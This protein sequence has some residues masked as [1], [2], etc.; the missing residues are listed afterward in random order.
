MQ[1]IK[2]DFLI[3]GSGVIGLALARAILDRFPGRSVTIIEKELDV[4]FHG[5]GRNSG[6]L[7]AGFYYT[8]DSLKAKFTADGNRAMRA[9]CKEFGL[10]INE[11]GKVVVAKNEDELNS[12][13][14][15]ERRG[16]R[17]GSTLYLI[18]EK[19]LSEI[20]PNA[21]TFK[22]A[23]FSPL[24]A[25]VDPVLV[26]AAMRKSLEAAGV[27]FRFDTPFQHKISRNSIR[28]GGKIFEFKKLI[29]AA[30]LY[31]DKVAKE[32]GFAGIYTIVPF[33]GIYLK[34][35]KADAPVRTNIYPVPNLKNPF[36]GVHFTV[37]VDGHIKIGPTAIPAFWRE[38]YKGIGGFS[39]REFF[40]ILQVE[41]GLFLRDDFGFR[42]LA[43][44]EM[45]KY[46]KKYFVGLA[47]EMVRDIDPAGFTDW[48]RPGI[49]AQLLNVETNQLVQDFLVEADRDSVHILNAVSPAFTGSIPFANWVVEKY[50]EAV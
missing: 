28:A 3:V 26:C 12:L 40:E 15:L 41:A 32:F 8:S 25:T 49:R 17:N 35:T 13:F 20:E 42:S 4:A 11:C 21:R 48:S 5:S 16:K 46:R 23:L 10:P 34:Y 44:E 39:S 18:D 2:S 7:H 43:L 50:V 31:A 1:P 47:R 27:T 30:G 22:K 9:Y 19:E 33:K 36:L 37:T 29:N 38:N 45:K 24:T 14:E 6:V